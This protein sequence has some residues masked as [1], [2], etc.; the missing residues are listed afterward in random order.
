MF[1]VT[2]QLLAEGT[3]IHPYLGVL[4]GGAHPGHP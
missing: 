1:D 4:P 2:K 3:A